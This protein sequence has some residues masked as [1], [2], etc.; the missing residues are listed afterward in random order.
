MKRIVIYFCVLALIVISISGCSSHNENGEYTVKDIHIFE[1]SEAWELA[2][3]VNNNNTFSINKICKEHPE[4]VDT[5][6][7]EYGVSLLTWAVGM[8][9]YSSVKALLENGADVDLISPYTGGTALFEACGFLW[10]D[11]MANKSP[12][13]VKLLLEHGADP[14]ICFE[15]CDKDNITVVGTSPLMESIGCG[16]E[17][18]N[19]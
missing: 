4:W 14:N 5:I 7:P 11:T 13:Y 19:F 15:G 17:K 1:K 12:K 3:A 2:K 8:D 6:D 18:P 10:T 16:L 9:K